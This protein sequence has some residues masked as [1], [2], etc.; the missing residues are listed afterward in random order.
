MIILRV[1]NEFGEVRW[2]VPREIERGNRP[3]D[4]PQKSSPWE[5]TFPSPC[6]LPRCSLSLLRWKFV[7]VHTARLRP[8]ACLMPSYID[9]R[10][11][12]EIVFRR[13][14][15]NAAPPYPDENT[16]TTDLHACTT[17]TDCRF[18]AKTSEI[19]RSYESVKIYQKKKNSTEDCYT[20]CFLRKRTIPKFGKIFLKIKKRILMFAIL[21]IK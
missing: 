2:R 14:L 12:S 5:R 18:N 21:G 8:R 20:E 13:F 1:L 7:I 19:R 11:E 9:P 10:R 6:F 4:R 17:S 3:R 15:R 16:H